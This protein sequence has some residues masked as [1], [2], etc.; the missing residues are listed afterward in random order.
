MLNRFT[1]LCLTLTAA[2]V[3]PTL[4]AAEEAEGPV[5][6]G[7]YLQSVTENSIFIVWRT[8]GKID[9]VVRYGEKARSLN[10]AS[11]AENV[12][13]RVSNDVEG[14]SAPQL[15]VE[16]DKEREKRE[17]KRK[18]DTTGNANVFQYEVKITGLT[19]A[20]KYYYQ[21]F[22]GETPLI[23]KKDK[24]FHFVTSPVIG[25]DAPARIWVVG[26]SGT[27]GRDQK[28]V[29]E[30]MLG[31]VD[32]TK[33][34]LDSFIHVGD[35]AYSDGANYEFDR[36]FF[37]VYQD[38][39]RNVTVWAAM[40]NHEGKTSRGMTETGPY[41]DAYI[42]PRKG[43]AGGVPSGTEAY[44]SYDLGRIHF[45][46]LDSHDLDRSSTGA[47]ATWLREDL[48]QADADWLIAFWHHPPYTKGSHD[49]DKEGQLIEMREQIMPIMEEAG[50]DLVLTGHSHIYERS[51]LVDGAYATPTVAEGVILD[52]G[53]GNPSGD[54]AYR[55][56]AGLNPHEGAVQIVAG[57]GGAGVRR[58][59]TM[60]IMREIIVE[61]GSV[62]L[63][64]EGDTLLGHM[65]N[66]EGDVR[67]V[68]SIVKKGKVEVK[69]I[70]NP[71][72]PE[73]WEKK[74]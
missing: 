66:K 70:E 15:Y 55:K 71:W 64:V 46:C 42:L 54:G 16:T 22:D 24:G 72:Q 58:T 43:E 2:L 57:H 41:Y 6:R 63:D 53:D 27:G 10:R 14:L 31:F 21:V 39:L 67:D 69:R 18:E 4:W 8:R 52:D 5:L 50:V 29:Y 36:G 7:P 45:V 13:F 59:G 61:H 74:K 38:V 62:I 1:A 65:I 28:E 11:T 9:P 60:P 68:F 12:V 30:A 73:H 19:P 35:M 49:S 56:S 37:N 44:Y 20:T 17:K 34:P 33:K 47:M 48:N 26:D 3:S 25:S 32:D 23:P 51:M 40:G